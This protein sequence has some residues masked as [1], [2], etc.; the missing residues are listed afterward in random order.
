MHSATPVLVASVA[1]G[2]LIGW[3]YVRPLY[4]AADPSTLGSSPPSW[5][6][7]SEEAWRGVLRSSP[8]TAPM[9]A[10]ML[11]CGAASMAFGEHTTPGAVF[12]LVGAG[13]LTGAFALAVSVTLWN[14]PRFVVPPPLRSLP[15]SRASRP[16]ES[17]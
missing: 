1:I 2:L 12:A 5:W 16:S 3:L 8:A 17:P 4:W 15:G 6:L 9:I 10:L 14:R 7:L 11:L 13:L